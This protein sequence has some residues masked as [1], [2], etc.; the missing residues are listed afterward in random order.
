MARSVYLTTRVE[1]KVGDETQPTRV[2][3][4]RGGMSCF[5]TLDVL[6]V[7]KWK[8]GGREIS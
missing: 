2:G 8:R 4:A 5:E 1:K 3:F 6:T 7:I